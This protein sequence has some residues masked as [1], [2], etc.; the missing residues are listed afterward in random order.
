VQRRLPARQTGRG[1][2]RRTHADAE[3]ET[4]HL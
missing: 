2:G 3:A 4:A 1:L